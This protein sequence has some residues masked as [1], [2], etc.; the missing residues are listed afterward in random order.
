MSNLFYIYNK[1]HTWQVDSSLWS[2]LFCYRTSDVCTNI[3]QLVNVH[4]KHSLNWETLFVNV[5]CKCCSLTLFT[6]VCTR[7]YTVYFVSWSM[8]FCHRLF[9]SIVCMQLFRMK[10][11]HDDSFLGYFMKLPLKIR[12][13]VSSINIVSGSRLD[14]RGL[15]PSTGKRILPHF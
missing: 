1:S 10:K 14:K 11:C 12:S 15:I 4:K 8:E 2:S 13:S 9:R 3:L 7:R 6:L 5:V